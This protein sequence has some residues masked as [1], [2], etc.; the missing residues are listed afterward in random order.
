M[1]PTPLMI[2]VCLIRE[3]TVARTITSEVPNV[4]FTQGFMCAG[5]NAS[6]QLVEQGL[7]PSLT[8]V[9]KLVSFSI[10]MKMHNCPREQRY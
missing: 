7:T 2:P 3:Q 10:V 5:A 4:T 1:A 6:I 9:F 8:W